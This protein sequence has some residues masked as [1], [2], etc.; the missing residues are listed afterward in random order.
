MM[1]LPAAIAL[2]AGIVLLLAGGKVLRPVAVVLG[3]AA[4]G[5]GGSVLLP[6]LLPDNV[7]GVP[8]NA[9]G[10]GIGTIIGMVAAA[11]LFRAAMAAAGAATFGAAGVLIAGMTLGMSPQVPASFA[12]VDKQA[13]QTVVL[14]SYPRQEADASSNVAGKLA[15]QLWGDAT[16]A[17]GS[18]P[19][20]S[21]M[22]LMASGLGAG[23]LGLMVGAMMPRRAAA[24]VTA[25][26]G[27][28]VSLASFTWIAQR[29][30]WPGR[31]LLEH[32]PMGWLAICGVVAAAG[33]VFQLTG[34]VKPKPQPKQAAA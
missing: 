28:G 8:G 13:A 5:F 32:G 26:L 30:E 25:L 4:G 22:R 14:A 20:D 18:L 31:G 24:L 27:A 15:E 2:V 9:V 10:M 17:W 19:S 23:L 29:A 12:N 33:L 11:V 3:G 16:V 1:Y 21:K 34:Q 6:G 7:Y